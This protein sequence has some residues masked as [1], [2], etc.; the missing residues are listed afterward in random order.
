[1]NRIDRLS[2]ILIMLQSRSRTTM[3]DI[4]ERFELSRRTIFRDIRALIETGVPIGGDAGDGYFIAEGYHLPPVVFSKEEAASLLL[5]SKFIEKNADAETGR[6]M[7]EALTKV[8]AVLRYA[9]REFLEGLENNVTILPSPSVEIEG[10]PESHLKDI[11]FAIGSKRTLEFEYQSNYKQEL[12]KREVEP[13]GLVYYSSRWHLIAYC[14]LR[15]DLRDF[16]TDRI[17]KL[18]ITT[19]TF[20]ADR[21]PN[22]LDFLNESLSGTDAKVAWLRL[23]KQM[24]RF[25]GEQKYYFGFVEQEEKE[26]CVRMKFITPQY[27]YLGRWIMS[28]GNQIT[29]ESPAELQNLTS[30]YAQELYAHYCKP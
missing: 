13:L 20:D 1:M 28:Y 30:A 27:Q 22:Y 2:A 12:T 24:A 7:N 25:L 23:T 21:H 16:R 29:V 19:H 8:K 4:E 9:D 11:Q 26:D 17:Q 14:Q 15:E 10:F 18:R 5:G 6:T 3:D